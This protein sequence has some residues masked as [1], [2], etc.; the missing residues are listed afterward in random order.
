MDS[1]QRAHRK[2][3]F[4][5]GSVATFALAAAL[6]L[7]VTGGTAGA[8]E[9][10]VVNNSST[11]VTLNAQP[12]TGVTG[13]TT[14]TMNVSASQTQSLRLPLCAAKSI[15][16]ANILSTTHAHISCTMNSDMTP[17]SE[18]HYDRPARSAFYWDNLLNDR[19]ETYR[20][21]CQD[22]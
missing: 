9:I 12:Y 16:L 1:L 10:T 2:A 15:V 20:V 4:P 14:S 6:L 18:N 8:V 22:K 13:C 21:V 19:D 5:C 11:K 3:S 17:T 7:A